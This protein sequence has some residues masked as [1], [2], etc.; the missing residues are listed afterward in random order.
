MAARHRAHGTAWLPS[1]LQASQHSQHFSTGRRA[2]S[3][4]HHELLATAATGGKPLEGEPQPKAPS[5]I[6]SSLLLLQAPE[7][8][9]S[10]PPPPSA[11]LDED[12]VRTVLEHA[13]ARHL[14]RVTSSLDG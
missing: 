2:S 4:I 9:P 6:K 10:A 14:D 5:T 13:R 11:V 7:K 3:S 12:E 8:L 1:L